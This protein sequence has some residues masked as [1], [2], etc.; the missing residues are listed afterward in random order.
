MITNTMVRE[1][2]NTK[3]NIYINKQKQIEW[4]KNKEITEIPIGR[5]I[6]VEPIHR[7]ARI[8]L[9]NK[10][11]HLNEYGTT[12]IVNPLIVK[13][14]NEYS[15]SLISNLKGYHL[16]RALHQEFVPVVIIDYNREQYCQELG[17]NDNVKYGFRNPNSI[18]VKQNFIDAG[19]SEWKMQKCIDYYLKY[20]CMD[21]P[22]VI[23]DRVCL[24]GYAR[25]CAAQHLELDKVWVM[26]I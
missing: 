6:L 11:A 14:N 5:I 9:D 4:L 3:K 16:A 1:E 26:Y 20:G 10:I 2:K 12:K 22:V 15:Y 7:F 8:C 23:R 21:K 19:V 18:I 25:L 24:D 13:K 17:I